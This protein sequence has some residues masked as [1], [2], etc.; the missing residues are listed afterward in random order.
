MPHKDPIMSSTPDS[1]P[2]RHWSAAE[3]AKL[4]RRHFR[5]G[6]P[7]AT[8]AD[9]SG[10][11]PSM[12]HAWIRTVLDGADQILSDKRE[13]ESQR[14][15]KQSAAKD[16]RIRHLEEVAAELSMEV[17]QLKKARIAPGQLRGGGSRA[18][19]S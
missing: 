11:A 16:D 6:I 2:R 4:V 17:L 9:E 8:L 19:P 12:V 1:K 14:T 3:K 5:D 13:R 10:T 7:V 15:E 18:A